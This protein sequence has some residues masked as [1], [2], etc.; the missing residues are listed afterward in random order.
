MLAGSTAVIVGAGGGIGS[1]V[2]R[3]MAAPGIRL[4]LVYRSSGERVARLA[5]EL[6]GQGALCLPI[7]ADV[8]RLGDVEAMVGR[9]VDRFGAVDVLVNTQ[10]RLSRLRWFLEETAEEIDA[11]VEVELKSVMHCCRAAGAVMV[12]R[13]GGRIVTVGSDSGKVGS[14]A[15]AVSSACRGGVIAFSKA[16]AREWARHAV[17]VNVVCPGPTETGLLQSVREAGGVTSEVLERMIRTIPMRRAGTAR[18]VADVVAFL[19][20][21][22]ASY[23]TGQA[24]S[25]SGG[26]TMC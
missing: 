25:V 10:G 26:L 9:V 18:E 19:A 11:Y 2:A 16:L 4:G 12:R 17:T 3:S 1:A 22:E 8:T 7:A 21:R 5:A 6:E 24:I 13:G 23:V 15:E 14:T 20:S